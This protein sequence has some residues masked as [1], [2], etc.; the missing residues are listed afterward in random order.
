VGW[1]DGDRGCRVG[2]SVG[3]HGGGD[4][5]GCC[6]SLF[7]RCRSTFL[8]FTSSDTDLAFYGNTNP[9]DLD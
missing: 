4:G 2:R 5:Q 3:G 6:C 1:E 9:P 8:C 7:R